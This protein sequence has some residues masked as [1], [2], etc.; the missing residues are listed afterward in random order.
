[1]RHTLASLV[2][3]LFLF[4]SIA[5]GERSVTIDD[6]IFRSSNGLHYKKYTDVPFSGKVTGREQGLFKNAMRVG[7]WVH[8]HIDGWLE[9]KGTY[10]NGKKDGPWVE[11]RKDGHISLE[12]NFKQDK[13]D[14]SVEY[15][16]SENGQLEFKTNY[17]EGKLHGPLTFYY[18]DG[19]LKCMGSLTTE[20]KI[21]DIKYIICIPVSLDLQQGDW[22]YY[23]KNGQLSS[24]GTYK[25]GKKISN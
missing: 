18:P 11:Y 14:T 19:Q 16:Y 21:K 15:N 6:L 7:L 2:L 1:M 4:P 8:Y 9:S 5:K 13:E 22:V 3:A 17:K 24:K 12:V 10:V 25:D 23:H 20:T